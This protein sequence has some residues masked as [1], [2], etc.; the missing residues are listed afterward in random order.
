MRKHRGAIVAKLFACAYAW[1][2]EIAAIDCPFASRLIPI[3]AT[4]QGKITL[5]AVIYF[6]RCIAKPPRSI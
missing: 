6:S 5:L 4:F 3:N 1:T 2:A